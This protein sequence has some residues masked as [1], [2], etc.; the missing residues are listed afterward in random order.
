M[1]KKAVYS[2]LAHKNV[3]TEIGK[4]EGDVRGLRGL[5]L[6]ARRYHLLDLSG[7]TG[8][9]ITTNNLRL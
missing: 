6:C 3:Q 7:R 1:E 9:K 5:E 4:G 2:L 8:V